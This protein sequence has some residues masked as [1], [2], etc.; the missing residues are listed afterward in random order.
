[1]L[2]KSMGGGSEEREEEGGGE[3]GL[4]RPLRLLPVVEVEV[5]VEVEEASTYSM[6]SSDSSL[7]GLVAGLERG[8]GGGP[9]GGARLCPGGGPDGGAR[10]FFEDIAPRQRPGRRVSE[11]ADIRKTG[12]NRKTSVVGGLGTHTAHSNNLTAATPR[13]THAFK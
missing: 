5:E 2:A 13:A 1:M 4:R 8:S 3:E 12:Q 7:L 11:V 6:L 9:D 10:L